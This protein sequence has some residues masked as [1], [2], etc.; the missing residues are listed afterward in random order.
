MN[1]ARQS[2]ALTTNQY[3]VGTAS[4]LDVIT[5]QVAALNSER[6]AAAIAGSRIG[7]SILLVK[8]LGG[9]WDADHITAE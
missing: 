9:G 7:A 8:A 4:A 2:L 5:T 6:A 3:K 1:A